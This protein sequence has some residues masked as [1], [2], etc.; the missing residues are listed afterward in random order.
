MFTVS[1]EN[2]VTCLEGFCEN[3]S[4][5]N[6][7]L[8][9]K[10]RIKSLM[11]L[12]KIGIFPRKSSVVFGNLRLSSEIFGSIREYSVVFGNLPK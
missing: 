12:K 4:I 5:V 3:F 2:T 7:Y 1:G 10:Y 11:N 6:F 9:S 8:L